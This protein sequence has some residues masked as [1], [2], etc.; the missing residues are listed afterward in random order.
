MG[1]AL[2]GHDSNTIGPN[3]RGEIYPGLWLKSLPKAAQT[4]GSPE[5]DRAEA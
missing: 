4:G 3:S 1:M 5:F 2:S